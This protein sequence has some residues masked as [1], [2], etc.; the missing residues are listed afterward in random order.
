MELQTEITV[1]DLYLGLDVAE[2]AM[3]MS[4]LLFYFNISLH[5][6]YLLRKIVYNLLHDSMNKMNW[7]WK[8]FLND[9]FALSPLLQDVEAIYCVNGH[10]V[11]LPLFAG[12]SS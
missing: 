8:Q 9:F 11:L 2:A 1:G 4:T 6:P 3:K 7:L 10:N 5:S 12:L